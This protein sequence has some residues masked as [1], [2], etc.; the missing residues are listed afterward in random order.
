MMLGIDVRLRALM[1]AIRRPVQE[2]FPVEGGRGRR[3]RRLGS[4]LSLRE[5]TPIRGAEGNF[6][7]SRT[8]SQRPSWL[9]G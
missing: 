9:I 5:R 4:R 3:Q 1:H 6:T 8:H 2:G 7:Q